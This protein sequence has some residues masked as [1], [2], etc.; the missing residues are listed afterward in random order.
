MTI[1]I[2]KILLTSGIVIA[3]A[4]GVTSTSALQPFTAEYQFA[5]NGKNVG[6]AVRKL[7]KQN[8]SWTY[9]DSAKAGI[10]ASVSQTS[11]FT[12]NNGQIQPMSFQRASKI[13]V[14]SRNL[15]IN[16]NPAARTVSSN[17]DGKKNSFSWKNNTLD[18]LNVELQVREDLKKNALK[19]QYLI[20]DADE[21]EARH[22]IK[23]GAEKIKTNA[24][25]FNTIKVV[26]QHKKPNR[27]TIFW[28]APSLDYLPIKVLH[29]DKGT[30]YGLS[31]KSYKAN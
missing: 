14:S 26:I 30:S 21:I 5:Y 24:G 19:S 22:F 1:H 12:F 16:F 13:L 20:A 8:N 25:T 6:T 27:S 18:E 7:S 31:L 9:Q 3:S 17:K 10:A 2:K 28:L 4:F 23:Q 11:K 29:N 15:S